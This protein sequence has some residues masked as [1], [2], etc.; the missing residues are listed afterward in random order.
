MRPGTKLSAIDAALVEKSVPEMFSDDEV[1]GLPEPVRRYLTA[2][3][4]PG[5]RLARTA[6]LQ[7]RGHIKIGRWLPFQARQVLTPHEGFL[8]RARVGGVITGYDQYARGQGGMNWKLAGLIRIAHGEGPDVARAAAER[9]G[10]EAMWL[11]TTLL[12]RF[13]VHWRAIDDATIAAEF[14]VDG[15]PIE[16]RSRIDDRGRLTSTVFDRWHEPE[17]AGQWALAP[18]GGDVTGYCTFDGL[19]IPNAGRFG[20]HH[21][22]DRWPAGEFIRYEITSLSPVP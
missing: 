4:A 1:R 14:A 21:G 15:H 2:A 10:A 7:M 3:I 22:T 6:R 17:G 12:P 19:T 9:A 5:T 16:V 18:F 11:P 20:W 13:G 8:W